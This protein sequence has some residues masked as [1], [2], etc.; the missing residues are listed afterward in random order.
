MKNSVSYYVP[1]TLLSAGDTNAKLEKSKTTSY[2]LYMMPHTAN[3]KGINVCP[4]A[5]KGCAEA[6]LVSAGRGKFSNVEKS[7]LNKTEFWI[8]DKKGFYTLLAK[9]IQKAI[10]KADK[11]GERVAFRLNGT[12]DLD[13]LKMLKVFA[14]FDYRDTGKNVVF[15]D[16]TKVAKKALKYLGDRKYFQTFSRSEDN[17]LQCIDMLDSGVNVAVVFRDNLPKYWKGFPV[18][19]GD[20]TDERFLDASGVVVGLKAKGDAKKDT[21]GFVV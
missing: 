19:D 4:H 7:R 17:E 13:H 6:C 14:G 11:K 21:S 8:A 2:I 5:S 18:I 15:Y 20:Q 3:S 1:K 12:S 16:Y 10:R 9:D